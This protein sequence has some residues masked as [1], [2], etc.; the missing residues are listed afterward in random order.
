ME[1]KTIL[2]TTRI[3]NEAEVRSL[4]RIIVLVSLEL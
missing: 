3:A 1:R 2:R 4:Y